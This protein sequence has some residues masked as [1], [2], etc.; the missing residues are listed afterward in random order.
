MYNLYMIKFK[1]RFE[2]LNEPNLPNSKEMAKKHGHDELIKLFYNEVKYK[3]SPKVIESLEF[4][5][6]N[7][8]P[9]YK[10]PEVLS[11]FA[12][13]YK[14]PKDYFYFSNGSDAILDMIPTLFAS[15]TEGNNIVIPE[16]TFGR[17]ETTALVNDIP[18]K[19]VKLVDGLIDLNKTL[20][21]IDEKTSI[22]Y[23]VN[24]NMP[25]GKFNDEKKIIGFMEKVPENVLVVLDEAYSEIARG[26]EETFESNKEL[27]EKFDNLII[28]HTFS[29]MYA[30]ASMRIGYMISKPYIVDLFNKAYQ[31]LPVNKYSLQA[32]AA[33]I[34]DIDYYKNIRNII[35]SEKEKYYKV[36]N[37]LGMKY[38]H[39]YGNFIYVFTED[40]KAFEDYL[41]KKYGVLIRSV[42][43]EAIR[44]SI[45]TIEE[46]KMVLD[47]LKE[48]YG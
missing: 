34:Q 32:A 40:N 25:T 13:T 24:P 12:D 23:V 7:L 31:Y 2:R 26:F 37:E 18:I 6:V 47:G 14:L 38:Y 21:A 28:T 33:A 17:I 36:L 22:V 11:I 1:E 45:G 48:Y 16:L 41:V 15:K 4:K 42:R 3:P 10:E 35:I 30:L 19:K 8:Y 46:N 39:S 20:E 27:I 9:E 44:I 29:K 5:S 43:D